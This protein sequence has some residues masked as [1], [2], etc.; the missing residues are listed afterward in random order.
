MSKWFLIF[1]VDKPPVRSLFFA[2]LVAFT[3]SAQMPNAGHR[4]W[5]A[6]EESDAAYGP[7][8]VIVTKSGHARGDDGV[9]PAI[10]ADH[11][12][13]AILHVDDPHDRSVSLVIVG[14]EDRSVIERFDLVVAGERRVALNSDDQH[15][16]LARFEDAIGEN[17]ELAN[18]YL[19]E[20]DFHPVPELFNIRDSFT[21]DHNSRGGDKRPGVRESRIGVWVISYDPD[22]E[23]LEISDTRTGTVAL[24]VRQPIE[25]YGFASPGVLCRVRPAPYRGWYDEGSDTAII[26]LGYFWS[27]HGCDISDKWLIET[28]EPS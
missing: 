18:Q 25:V 3:A 12:N 13:V 19:S 21:G 27:G 22:A 16:A 26:R 10:S 24:R 28:L 17:L 8:T 11:H 4:I 23:R 5:L 14:V 6:F 20:N 15:L 2:L 1:R 9:F 7:A